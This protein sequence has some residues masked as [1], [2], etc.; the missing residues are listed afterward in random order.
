MIRLD[1]IKNS[2]HIHAVK[3]PVAGLKNGNVLTLGGLDK[4]E[5]FG[6]EVYTAAAPVAITDAVVFVANPFVKA[7]ERL[8]EKDYVI[9]KDEVVRTLVL[10]K[11]DIITVTTDLIS[12][13]AVI[14]QFVGLEAGSSV[15][16]ASA[17]AIAGSLSFVVD[18]IETDVPDLAGQ[19]GVVLRVL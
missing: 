11:G 19:T 7:D 8:K 5:V 4:T 12:G 14:K 9:E 18:D 6:G 2:T 10:E 15:L 16:K 13:S 1:K 3:S 17:T